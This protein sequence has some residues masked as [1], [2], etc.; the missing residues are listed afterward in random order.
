MLDE[1]MGSVNAVIENS[2][3]IETIVDE[4]A[5]RLN[6]TNKSRIIY[7]GAGTSGRIAVQD[8]VELT[9][10]FGWPKVG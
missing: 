3:Q 7:C 1:Q 10:T 9:P 2:K 4:I 6:N 8:G 5:A